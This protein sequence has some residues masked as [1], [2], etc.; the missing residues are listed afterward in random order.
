MQQMADTMADMHAQMRQEHQEMR[1]EREDIRREMRQEREEIRQE[2]RAQQQQQQAPLPP[3][4]PPAPPRDKHREFMSHKPPTFSNSADPLQADD[5]L[6]SVEK[7]LNITQCLDREKVLYA[8]G[9]LTGPAA[10]WWDACCAAHATVDTITWAEFSTQF[11]NYHIPAGL[12]KIKRKEFL[13]LKQGSMSVSE[14]RD[15]FIQLSRYAPRDVEDDEK[16]QELFLDG[17]IGPLQYQLVSHTFPSFQRLLD[18]AIAVENKRSIFG[19]KRRAANQGQA[20]SSSRPRYTTTPSTPAGGSSGQQTK[21]APTAP[22]QA[23]TPVGPVAPNTSTNRAC[24]KCGQPGH[25]ANYS[26]NRAAYTTPAPMKQGQASAGKSQPLSINRGQAHHAE[27]EVELGELEIQE[28]EL[29]EDEVVG[30]EV[31]EQQE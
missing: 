31:N 1:Q 2:R 19:E 7:M 25:Y 26:P 22:P 6:K 3:P 30:E 11:R 4:P 18:K 15:K 17:L 21:R 13:S 27:V 28:E 10:D 16:K 8:S 14:Y 12:M 24:F 23:S 9:R 29:V 5:W 20:G